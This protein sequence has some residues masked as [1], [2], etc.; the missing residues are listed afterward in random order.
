[1]IR[2]KMYGAHTI[3]CV[4]IWIPKEE[5]VVKSKTNL[6]PSL[7]FPRVSLV[8]VNRREGKHRR[9]VDDILSDLAKLDEYS[10]IQIDLARAGTGKANLRAALHRAA[11]KR[12]IALAT[13]SDQRNLYVFRS[14]P[15]METRAPGTPH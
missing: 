11:K 8:E 9:I 3:F 12:N 13:T 14:T 1:M 15:S 7:H 2:W 10:A 5:S 6:G 4:R